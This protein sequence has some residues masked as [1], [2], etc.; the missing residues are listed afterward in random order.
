MSQC[1]RKVPIV[2]TRRLVWLCLL[3]SVVSAIPARCQDSTSKSTT[4]SKAADVPYETIAKD[5][6]KFA[7]TKVSWVGTYMSGRIS[8]DKNGKAIERTTYVLEPR[9]DLAQKWRF[10]AVDT[11]AAVQTEAVKKL[12][13][14]PGDKGLR[15]IS[16]KISKAAEEITVRIGSESK[17]MSV[18]LIVDATIDAAAVTKP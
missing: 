7:G 12:G 5:P 14:T 9:A 1:N 11:L 2:E 3:V 4:A 13:S 15:K 18:P 10:F 8:Q 16:G 6:S 17:K